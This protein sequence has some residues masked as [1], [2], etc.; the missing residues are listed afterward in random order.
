MDIRR[1]PI[2][3]RSAW[4]KADFENDPSYVWQLSD[5][6][7]ED[8]DRALQQA[9][10]KGR[11]VADMRES[12][13]NLPHLGPALKTIQDELENGRGFSVIRG[14]P[15]DKYTLDELDPIYFAMVYHLGTPITQDTKGTLIEQ[16]TD[17]GGSYQSIAVRG[18]TTRAELTPH[19]DS[20]DVVGLL[21]VRPALSGGLSQISSSMSIY[22]ELLANHPEYLEPLYRGFHYN[23]RG[24][25]PA[26]QWE[27]V[28]R[29][30]VPVYSYRDGI[31]S[32]RFN[33]KAIKTAEQLPGVPPL[34]ELEHAAIDKV[35][36]L[37]VRPDMRVDIAMQAGD[38]QFL[39]NHWVLHT[40]TAY[41]DH[42]DPD[43]KRL[44]LRSWI[45]VPIGR[46][47]DDAFADHYN[48]GPRQGPP[49]RE[50]VGQ[51]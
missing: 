5:D 22:N 30:R 9:R 2:T 23:I 14:V 31:L 47:L 10:E 29:H 36:E 24:N 50:L 49:V 43:R 6:E 20:G 3:D 41:E 16:V 1:E 18:Y 38:I 42:P 32:C 19:C 13:F 27:D 35:A 21:C 17:R 8:I 25:G 15:V 51:G 39:N 46:A 4:R 33:H 26:G 12:D 7:V 45:N 37:A 48:T 28:T 40:R 11:S 34:T 44:L